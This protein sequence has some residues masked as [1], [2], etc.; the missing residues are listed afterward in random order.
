MTNGI[1]P[2]D[3]ICKSGLTLMIRISGDAACVTPASAE[4]L[5]N[6]GFGI[7]KQI[8]TVKEI[9]GN[10]ITPTQAKQIAE[11]AFIVTYP[12]LENYKTMYPQSVDETSSTYLVPF[13]QI[14][15]S[16]KLF[17]P[18]D[19]LIVT[20]NSDTLYSQIWM[21]LRSEPQ[22]LSIPVIEERYYSF[23]NIDFFGNNFDY[24][25]SRTTG[26]Q[27]GNFLYVGPNWDGEVPDE[28][29][30]VLKTDTNIV[31]SVGRTQVFG[32]ADL[33]TT[34]SIMDNYKIQS[35]SQFLNENS[36]TT[37]PKINFIPWSSEKA[38]NEEFITYVN[39]ILTFTPI[40][41]SEK[42]FFA[43]F[44]KIG[45]KTGEIVDFEN[46][47]PKIKEAIRSGVD[48]AYKK[49]EEKSNN[50][51]E[52][53]NGWSKAIAFGDR[54]FY[55]GDYL[56]RAG[57]QMFG[58]YGNDLEEA[59]YPMGLTDKD[60]NPMDGSKN[61]Y[62]IK[63]T[64]EPPVQ[65]FW[66]VTMYERETRLLVENPIDRWLI[67]N[68]SDLQKN[69]D[70]SFEVYLQH[71]S[72]GEDKE[73]NWLPAPNG[74]FHVMMRLYH[75]DQNV[76]DQTW[77]MPIIEKVDLT[78]EKSNDIAQD[79][80]P[81]ILLIV[82]DDVGYSDLGFQASKIE[83]PI[84][85]SLAENEILMTNYHVSPTCSPT[86]AMMLTGVD[87]HLNGIGSM[88]EAITDAQKGQPGYETSKL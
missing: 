41:D 56:L 53:E 40:H 14:D 80:R 33:E 60:E 20:P 4:K 29:T 57:G 30:K 52:F 45:I 13:N 66:S 49:I 7:I 24:I 1:A 28:I 16:K 78:I 35:L 15:N 88:N 75:P 10:T 2:E 38:Y 62:V 42:K 23:H 46:M 65:G 71:K 51:G 86:R 74:S 72:P 18:E 25:G 68:V 67:N 50:L 6:S 17:T 83:T 32:E 48:S 59:F 39:L 26:V 31:K 77:V 22:V 55:S 11:H 43:E 5:V 81:N 44:T 47:D 79:L 19:T 12:M 37:A 73:S 69:E 84:M 8:G 76:V 58:L 3:V 64:E 87:N 82:L 61:N 85:N 70:G 36:H 27:G 9:S 34:I 21:D 63:F 54:E